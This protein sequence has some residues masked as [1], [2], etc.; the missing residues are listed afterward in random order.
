M[1][2]DLCYFV[3]TTKDSAVT[4]MLSSCYRPPISRPV[5]VHSGIVGGTVDDCYDKSIHPYIKTMHQ[6]MF[7][8][9][10]TAR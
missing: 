2:L 7:A 6:H 8:C 1:K 10:C 3:R 9:L 4:D 5:P